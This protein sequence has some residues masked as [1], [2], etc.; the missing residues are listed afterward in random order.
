MHAVTDPSLLP[1]VIRWAKATDP[2]AFQAILR[3][4]EHPKIVLQMLAA[5][6]EFVV[7]VPSILA[8]ITTSL[9]DEVIPEVELVERTIAKWNWPERISDPKPESLALS[10]VSFLET[11]DNGQNT[12]ATIMLLISFLAYAAGCRATT[13]REDMSRI[14]MGSLF[15]RGFDAMCSVLFFGR[16]F[17][18]L[19]EVICMLMFLPDACEDTLRMIMELKDGVSNAM[20]DAKSKMGG[21]DKSSGS[22]GDG[23]KGDGSKGEDGG[24]EG[25]S[26]DDDT[27]SDTG[28][29]TEENAE[30][31]AEDIE[32]AEAVE[33]V[34]DDIDGDGDDG[35][36]GG[37][38]GGGDAGME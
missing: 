30:E 35:G 7:E 34:A 26:G 24:D 14:E 37:D 1:A 16:W 21:D 12:G 20:D 18:Q 4:L 17:R 22:G 25:S 29:D 13:T 31:D 11:T 32:D 19:N 8:S 36:D 5:L 38:D 27:E 6:E 33:D 3:V 23:S 28:D 10:P 15:V 9:P 2:V